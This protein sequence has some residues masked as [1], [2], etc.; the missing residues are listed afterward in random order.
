MPVC[1]ARE[2]RWLTHCGSCA[3]ACSR[4][5]EA[6]MGDRKEAG[7]GRRPADHLLRPR[8]DVLAASGEG[9]DGD[10]QQHLQ[11]LA[12]RGRLARQ[13]G[14]GAN[15]PE[16]PRVRSSRR[17]A[18]S[19]PYTCRPD[20]S[21]YR[22]NWRGCPRNVW[23]QQ[24]EPIMPTLITN[25]EIHVHHRQVTRMADRL[26]RLGSPERRTAYV[27]KARRRLAAGPAD[28]RRNRRRF[29]CRVRSASGKMASHS[30]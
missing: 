14:G 6:R 4:S 29:R 15:G 10:G 3:P 26:W 21:S 2:G 5:A 17:Q 20:F 16:I 28:S 25:G 19:S 11:R 23:M 7:G 22:P 24:E 1:S 13:I 9:A 12:H 8:R 30:R 18:Y 27:E